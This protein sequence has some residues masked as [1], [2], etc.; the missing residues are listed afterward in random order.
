[1]NALYFMK[2]LTM[3]EEGYCNDALNLVSSLQSEDVKFRYLN[4]LACIRAS[5]KD[6]A[7]VELD[8]CL[9]ID[10]N[11]IECLILKGKLLWSVDRIEDGN[12]CF[13]RAHNINPNHNEVIEFLSI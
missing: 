1:M 7:F 12:D 6:L 2:G 8:K 13:W 9:K 4:A 3:I 5:N 11:N 10:P